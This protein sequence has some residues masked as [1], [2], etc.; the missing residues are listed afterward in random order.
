MRQQGKEIKKIRS[1]SMSQRGM[2]LIELMIAMGILAVGLGGITNVLVIAMATDNRNSKDTSST[3]AGAN[4]HRTN[5]RSTPEFQC[6]DNGHRLRRKL[7]DHCHHWRSLSKRNR[8][9]P[10][11]DIKLL[12]LRRHRS[13]A[14]IFLHPRKLRDA[15]CGLRWGRQYGR[16]LDV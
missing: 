16:A 9:Q 8:C 1:R 2:T 5:Q 7:L 4:G 3:S 10:G 13:N 14:G 6:H 12:K 15:I 11:D